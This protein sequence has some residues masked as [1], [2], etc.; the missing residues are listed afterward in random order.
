M[1]VIEVKVLE[2]S[3]IENMTNDIKPKKRFYSIEALKKFIEILYISK[4]TILDQD[5][6][7]DDLYFKKFF[8]VK[9]CTLSTYLKQ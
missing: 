5:K 9:N 1:N 8:S 4:H 6:K 2:K 7:L 3:L